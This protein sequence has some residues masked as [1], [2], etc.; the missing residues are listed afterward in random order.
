VFGMLALGSE[1]AQRFVPE[2]GTVY[3][4]RIGE[5]CAATATARL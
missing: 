2:M 4:R 5:L 3:L 1:D